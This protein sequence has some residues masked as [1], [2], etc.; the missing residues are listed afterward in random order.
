MKSIHFENNRKPTI[1][2]VLLIISLVIILLKLFSSMP[3]IDKIYPL[4]FL[5]QVVF[6]SRMFF[7]KNFVQRNKNAIMIKINSFIGK[8]ITFDSLKEVS[9]E[10][11][12]LIIQKKNGKEIKFD[13]NSI[14]PIDTNKLYQILVDNVSI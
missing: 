4:A 3:F 8:T 5:I 11:K 13:M 12:Q 6:F 14:N 1:W 7:Y 10:A 9:L 2:I